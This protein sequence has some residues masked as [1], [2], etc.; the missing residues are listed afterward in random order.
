MNGIVVSSWLSYLIL[1][2]FLYNTLCIAMVVYSAIT[3][4]VARQFLA[5]SL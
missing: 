3:L 2:T 1:I 4:V 5:I